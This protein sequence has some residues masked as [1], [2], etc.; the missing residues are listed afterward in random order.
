M[1]HVFNAR[2]EAAAK[3]AAARQ[4]MLERYSPEAIGQLIAEEA[5]RINELIPA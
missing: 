3:G 5:H 2:E 1:R 4:R